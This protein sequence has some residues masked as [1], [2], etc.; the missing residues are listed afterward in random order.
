MTDSGANAKLLN[1]ECEGPTVPVFGYEDGPDEKERADGNH[2]SC[3]KYARSASN[4]GRNTYSIQNK[5]FGRQR[6]CGPQKNM[7]VPCS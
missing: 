7:Y 1:I 2:K 3:H 5:D 6:E 4:L